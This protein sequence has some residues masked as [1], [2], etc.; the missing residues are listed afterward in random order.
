MT[1]ALNFFQSILTFRSLKIEANRHEIELAEALRTDALDLAAV[2]DEEMK[3]GLTAQELIM[4]AAD[5]PRGRALAE[6][7]AWHYSRAAE[8]Y[9]R[10]SA[11][12]DQAARIHAVRRRAL[13]TQS[14]EMTHRAAA[15]LAAAARLG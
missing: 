9:Q 13:R 5:R 7:A 14:T 11:G 12:F 8:K 4:K 10:A 2:G 15:A 1:D 6:I 3:N